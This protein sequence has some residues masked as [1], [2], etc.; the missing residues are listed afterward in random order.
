MEYALTPLASDAQ[1]MAANIAAKYHRTGIGTQDLLMGLL[2]SF[3]SVASLILRDFGIKENDIQPYLGEMDEDDISDQLIPQPSPMYKKVFKDASHLV[4]LLEEDEIGT[5]H[6]MIAIVHNGRAYANRILT[7]LS[8]SPVE[9]VDKILIQLGIGKRDL[10][11]REREWKKK[12]SKESLLNE[13]GKDITQLARENK[14]DP[15]AGRE[16]EIQRVIEILMRRTKNNPV[17][18]G[19]PGVGKTAIAEGLAQKIVSKDVPMELQKKRI[20]S[21]DMATLVAGTKYRGEF[22][23][24]LKKILREI[25]DDGNVILFVDELHTLVGAGGADGA[26]DASNIMKPALARGEIQLLGATTTTEYRKYVENDAALERRFATVKI[27]EPSKEESFKILSKLRP[28]YEKFHNVKISDGVIKAAIEF[29]SRY[30]TDRFLPDKAFDVL[31]EASVRAHLRNNDSKAEKLMKLHEKIDQLNHEMQHHLELM[32]YEEAANDRIEIK[33]LKIELSQKEA[34]NAHLQAKQI[35]TKVADVADVVSQ[36]TGVPVNQISKSE[37]ERLINL[38]KHLHERVIGQNKA[39]DAISK[40]IRRSRSGLADPHRPI[41]SFMFL[42]PTGVGKTELAKALADEMF[43]S[44][45][46]MIRIDMSEYMEKFT[47]SR[48]VG[49]PPGYKGYD[50]GGELTDKVKENPYSVVL[51][52][53]IEKAHPDI[54]NLLLQVLDDGHLTDAKGRKVDFTNTIIIMTSNLGATDLRDQKEVGFASRNETDEYKEMS[55]MIKKRLKQHFRPEF[56]NRIDDILIFHSLTKDDLH[57]IVKLMAKKIIVRAQKQGI[58]LKLTP[59]AIDTL[60]KIGYDQEYGARPLR[61]AMQTEVEDR[62]SSAIIAKEIKQ[63][64]KVVIGSKKGKL[65]LTIK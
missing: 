26:I 38:E 7:R 49:A 24:R 43:G 25:K 61:R 19:E 33:K 4:E 15:I 56:L 46:A 53:E 8:I 37:S 45:E 1:D 44:E 17:L 40:A 5:E 29:S 47:T 64:S 55:T 6:L 48:L 23:D 13:L 36:W 62:L 57:Q 35:Q 41:G 58:E 12:M 30:I 31:D 34:R 18:L 50:E 21:L 54:F 42:G 63:G 3:P 51:F 2:Q 39:I 16:K 52:D 32:E 9:I 65:E 22:E 28:T 10:Q 20:V 59:K 14:I 27:E 60:A 11:M